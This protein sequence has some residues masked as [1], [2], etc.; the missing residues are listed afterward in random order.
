[1]HVFKY[2][3]ILA[4]V[5]TKA[6]ITAL[7]LSNQKMFSSLVGGNKLKTLREINSMEAIAP[8]DVA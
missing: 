1:M 7:T 3:A 2:S 6:T 8:C 5:Y 4:L